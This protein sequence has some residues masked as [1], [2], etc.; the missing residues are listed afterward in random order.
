M[1]KTKEIKFEYI[2]TKNSGEA[3]IMRAMKLKL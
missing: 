3:E 2:I 1:E